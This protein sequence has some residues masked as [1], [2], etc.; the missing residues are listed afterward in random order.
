MTRYQIL[1][2]QNGYDI[3]YIPDEDRVITADIAKLDQVIYNFINNAINYTGDNKVIRIKQINKADVVRIE[4]TDNGKGISKELLPKI[5]DRYYRDAKVKR[6]VVGT[7]LGLSICQRYSKPTA[8]HTAF[9]RR[10]AKARPSG[11]KRRSQSRRARLFR[12]WRAG[13]RSAGWRR[14]R[15]K[16]KSALSDEV[17]MHSFYYISVCHGEITKLGL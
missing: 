12:K 11:L 10:R 13:F 2:E 4:V 16:Y 9:N 5:F 6:D 17:V 15:V 8:L 3:K 7:G 1:I 14:N